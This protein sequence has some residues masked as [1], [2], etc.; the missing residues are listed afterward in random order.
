MSDRQGELIEGQ[1]GMEGQQPAGAMG[2][3]AGL[4]MKEINIVA[5]QNE[6]R[7]CFSCLLSFSRHLSLP[8]HDEKIQLTLSPCRMKLVLV[9]NGFFYT[10]LL[11]FLFC[12]SLY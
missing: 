8:T 12:F 3:A 9:F 2:F 6:T 10:D 4:M 5:P 1:E 7:S 11:Y